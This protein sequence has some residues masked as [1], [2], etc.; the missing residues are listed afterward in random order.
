MKPKDLKPVFSWVDRHPLLRDMILYVPDYYFEHEKFQR[1]SFNEIFEND[2]P[3]ALE[4]CTGN[5]DWVLEKAQA[6]PEKNWIAVEMQFDRVRKI[7]AK[8]ENRQIK[9]LLIVCGEALTFSKFYLQKDEITQAYINFPDPWPK[10]KHAKNR[11]IQGPFLTE[12]SR[13]LKNEAPFTIVTDDV[14]YKNQA[15]QIC[16]DHEHFESAIEKP[17]FL[18]NPQGYGYSYFHDLWKK[19][20]KTIHF[21]Q[22]LNKK[23]QLI[24]QK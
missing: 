9:N 10:D 21:I 1:P 16:L 5:G 13:V 8:R 23:S 15:I 17:Y 22:F 7:W 18:E 20:G 24:C 19:L 11:L 2:N 3:I 12:V 4:Y 6:H 14:D